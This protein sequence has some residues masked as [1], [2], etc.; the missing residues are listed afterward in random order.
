MLQRLLRQSHR[1]ES[2]KSVETNRRPACPMDAGRNSRA[3]RAFR[4]LPVGGGRS[5]FSWASN[6]AKTHCRE[7]SCSDALHV[8]LR[9]PFNVIV[10]ILIAKPRIQMSDDSLNERFVFDVEEYMT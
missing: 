6:L 3:P 5:P 2:N 9:I 8:I 10:S 4:R 1:D 7:P